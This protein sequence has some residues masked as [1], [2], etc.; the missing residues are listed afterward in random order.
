MMVSKFETNGIESVI[1]RRWCDHASLNATEY[2]WNHLVSV[3]HKSAVFLIR[4][5]LCLPVIVG[6][7]SW[8]RLRL[9]F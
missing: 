4:S 3:Q 6:D 7:G 5:V 2:H 9:N 1:D 8:R